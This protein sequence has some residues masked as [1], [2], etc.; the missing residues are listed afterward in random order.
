MTPSLKNLSVAA[1]TQKQPPRGVPRKG[2]SENTQQTHA[3]V[4]LGEHHAEH[5]AEVA[6]QFY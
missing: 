5:H 3:E 1:S 4:R 2:C 6:E